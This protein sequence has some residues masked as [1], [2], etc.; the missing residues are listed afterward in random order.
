MQNTDEAQYRIEIVDRQSIRCLYIPSH[1]S[2]YRYKPLSN[3]PT[4]KKSKDKAFQEISSSIKQRYF[5]G[6]EGNPGSFF[7]K[8]TLIGWV[9]QGYGVRNG[10]KAIMQADN[11]QI[12]NFEGFQNVLKMILPKSLGFEEIEI[13]NM[14]VVFICNGGKDE[15]ILETA[16]GGISALI[17]MAWQIYMYSTKENEKFTVMIDEVENHLHPSMQRQVLSDLLGAFPRANFIV[18]THSPLVV[19]SVKESAIY[20]L[21]YNEYKKIE[22]RRLDF[23]KKA[24]TASEILDEVLGVS[25]TIPLWAEKKLND[26]V[27][28]FIDEGANASELYKIRDDLEEAGLGNLMP[29]AIHT[30]AGR[31]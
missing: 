6:N 23:D 5:N 3:I 9:I 4:S 11:E 20:V 13:R 19:G 30:M 18:S 14:E 27:S 1:R 29:S 2:I 28:K 31:E 8:N 22:S 21:T 26:I 24:R 7:M 17:D 15:F 16:S 10:E 12:K 25:V